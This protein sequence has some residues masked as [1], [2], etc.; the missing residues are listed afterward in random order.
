MFSTELRKP[1][2][3][4][5]LPRTMVISLRRWD[6]GEKFFAPTEDA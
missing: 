3:C 6:E 1:T 4:G 2:V 5:V